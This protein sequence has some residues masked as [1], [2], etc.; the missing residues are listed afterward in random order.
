MLWDFLMFCA[1]RLGDISVYS[2]IVASTVY[3][4]M[5]YSLRLFKIKEVEKCEFLAIPHLFMRICETF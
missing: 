2:H 4:N 3:G 5:E 1:G